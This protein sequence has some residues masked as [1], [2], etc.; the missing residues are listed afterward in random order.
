[1]TVQTVNAKHFLD[2]YCDEQAM[3]L[4]E[5]DIS[6]RLYAF[7]NLKVGYS[8]YEVL[9]INLDC[10]S[11]NNAFRHET[12]STVVGETLDKIFGTTIFQKT[13][14]AY[15]KTLFYAPSTVEDVY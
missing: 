11:W 10:S 6:K 12:V 13:H 2:M 1:M 3:T 9:Y 4:G 7:R 14:L 5:L 8:G 15:Q